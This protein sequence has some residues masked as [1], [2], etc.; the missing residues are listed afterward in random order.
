MAENKAYAAP[1]WCSE[2]SGRKE[3]GY[4]K[5]EASRRVGLDATGVHSF[6][7]NHKAQGIG[8]GTEYI[9]DPNFY[10]T[11]CPCTPSA[12]FAVGTGLG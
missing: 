6:W 11:P 7:Q 12:V 9:V 10:L 8:K 4:R 1:Y 3:P 2:R 5:S